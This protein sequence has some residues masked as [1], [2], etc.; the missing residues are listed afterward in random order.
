MKTNIT[1]RT[2]AHKAQMRRLGRLKKQ[3][4]E[5][6]LIEAGAVLGAAALLSLAL[7]YGVPFVRNMVQ[8]STFKSEVGMFH[9][10][11]QNATSNDADF[12][13]ETLSTLA[14][15]HAF[16]AAGARVSSDYSTVTG[17]FGGQVTAEPGTVTSSNDAI[18]TSYPVPK[19]VCSMAL[20]AVVNIFTE[21]SVNGTV[22]SGPSTT[23]SS[24]TAGSACA[25]G[26][27][28]AT[29]AMYTTRS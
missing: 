24:A 10:G 3:T 16:D 25:S 1:Q 5:L 21:V 4:G 8:S 26:G 11:I 9:T 15:N 12:S 28:T 29:V 6:S 17:I 2:P 19:A 22:V 14:Q 20:S 13:S 7:F 18:V 27:D 23:F